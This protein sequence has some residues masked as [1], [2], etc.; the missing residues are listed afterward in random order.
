MW[1]QWREKKER[2]KMFCVSRELRMFRV[3]NPTA[4][5]IELRSMVFETW[6]REEGRWIEK[7]ADSEL[8]KSPFVL[9]AFMSHDFALS[10]SQSLDLAFD[11]CG[12]L[13][14]KTGSDAEYEEKIPA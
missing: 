1:L 11:K 4:R 14:V 12:R 8:P 2:L 5:P 3:H 6:S 9:Q 10:S 13:R 7:F